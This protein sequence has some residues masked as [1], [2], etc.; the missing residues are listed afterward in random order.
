MEYFGKDHLPYAILASLVLLVFN[1]LPLLLL[2]L[3]PCRCFQRC[4]THLRV[5]SLALKIFMDAFQGCYKDGTTGTRDYRYFSAIYVGTRLLLLIIYTLTL[6]TYSWSLVS[7]VFA[8]VSIL[9]T[10]FQPYKS[11][12]YNLIDAIIF[13]ATALWGFSI[14]AVT[15]AQLEAPH[16]TLFSYSLTCL[17]GTVPLLYITGVFLHW[18]LCK[19]KV[20]QKILVKL[21]FINRS[22]IANLNT[23]PDR[24][25]NPDQYERLLPDPIGEGGYNS[26]SNNGLPTY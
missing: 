7:M 5:D 8:I 10:I 22:R 12:I 24:L 11:P 6:N 14:Q 1:V 13:F 19:K 26:C 17:F 15:V 2:L 20:P 9:C 3:Y 23:L 4:L 21:H 18:L 16:F 25:I